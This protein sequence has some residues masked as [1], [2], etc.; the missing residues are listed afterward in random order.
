MNIEELI[1]GAVMTAIYL[2]AN[3]AYKKPIL[4]DLNEM[5]DVSKVDDGYKVRINFL[6]VADDKAKL[7][8]ENIERI[9][10]D[11]VLDCIMTFVASGWSYAPYSG[12]T[13][14]EYHADYIVDGSVSVKY[15]PFDEEILDDR[16]YVD[17]SF[18][19]KIDK[20]D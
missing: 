14:R 6:E 3:E 15:H 1:K 13:I 12:R 7:P 17:M 18:V 16:N 8:A 4:A 5:I 10:G 19:I 9:F 20:E 2:P 11:W